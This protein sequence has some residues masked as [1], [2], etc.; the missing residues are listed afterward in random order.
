[1]ATTKRYFPEKS[2]DKATENALEFAESFTDYTVKSLELNLKTSQSIREVWLETLK[3]QIGLGQAF[4]RD[5]MKLGKRQSETLGGVYEAWSSKAFSGWPFI[6]TTPF[7]YTR[8]GLEVVNGAAESSLP[9]GNY[10][11]LSVEDISS[12]IEGLSVAE[13]EQLREYEL[14]TKGRKSLLEIYDRKLKA[15]L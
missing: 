3:G 13:I 11:E 12:R 14:F 8:K 15:S 1:M 6:S 4:S 9:I 10:D 2:F 7:E 5:L